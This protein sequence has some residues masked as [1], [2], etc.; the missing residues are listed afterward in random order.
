VSRKGG[1]GFYYLM[2]GFI[3]NNI[4]NVINPTAFCVQEGGEEGMWIELLKG[5]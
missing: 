4:K 2:M 3:Q 1:S 5:R